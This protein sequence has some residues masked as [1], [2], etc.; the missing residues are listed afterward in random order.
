MLL[1]GRPGSYSLIAAIGHFKNFKMIDIAV[2]WLLAVMP[3]NTT[4]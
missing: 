1:K 4:M 2:T 3:A